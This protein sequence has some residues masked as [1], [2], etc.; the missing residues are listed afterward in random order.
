MDARFHWNRRT[1]PL[2]SVH[3]VRADLASGQRRA[4]VDSGADAVMRGGLVR[5]L[6][7]AGIPVTGDS[8]I[9]DLGHARHAP[10]AM[11]DLTKTVARAAR[12][13][14]RCL[15]LGG[16]HSL[17]F[18]TIAGMLEVHGDLRVLYVDAHGDINTPH[19]SPTGN[20]HGMPLAAHLGLFDARRALGM[21]F[22][23]KRLAA[24]H[25]AFVGVRD[26]DPGERRFI[27]DL[28][29]TCFSSDDVHRR[30]MDAVL[31]EALHALDPQGRH[32]LH[33]S[34]DIDAMDPQIA[35]AT[36]LHVP[37]GLTEAQLQAL[38]RGL[39]RTGRLAGLDIAEV[40][41]ALGSPS[42]TARTVALAVDFAALSLADATGM[43]SGRTV[44][45]RA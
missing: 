43:D 36:G 25:L 33:V 30:G 41:P 29:I 24:G 40:N 31:D 32:P 7:A 2:S 44:A 26:L 38:G 20:S 10:D 22:L 35:P 27:T 5:R 18:G 9:G 28:G 13:G 14:E 39:G 23:K 17:A 34:F 12:R 21:K 45:A 42:D 8:R 11:R 16:D 6:A 19:T 4:G 3:V 15:T 37:G 1:L